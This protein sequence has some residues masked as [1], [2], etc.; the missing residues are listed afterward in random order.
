MGAAQLETH[1]KTR[2]SI[3]AFVSS[4]NI[5]AAVTELSAGRLP[6]RHAT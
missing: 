6:L 4:A 3:V 5:V 2:L 1:L